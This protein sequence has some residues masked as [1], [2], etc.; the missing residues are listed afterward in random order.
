MILSS[1]V[2]LKLAIGGLVGRWVVVS[3]GCLVRLPK[4]IGTGHTRDCFS[5][6]TNCCFLRWNGKE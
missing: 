5:A 6:K 4:G 2:L 1:I 3:V